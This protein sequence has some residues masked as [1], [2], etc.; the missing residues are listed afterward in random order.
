MVKVQDEPPSESAAGK[1]SPE[2]DSGP[3]GLIHIVLKLAYEGFKAIG[4]AAG[5]GEAIWTAFGLFKRPNRCV[6][7]KKKIPAHAKFCQHCGGEQPA[8]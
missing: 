5:D 8:A 4:E 2:T 1:P 7:C 6:I 3:R